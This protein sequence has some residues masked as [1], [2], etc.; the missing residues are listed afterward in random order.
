MSKMTKSHY[1]PFLYPAKLSCW[2]KL[3]SGTFFPLIF[4]QS[5]ANLGAKCTR[6]G[7]R[8]C[9]IFKTKSREAV[10]Y[11]SRQAS[12]TRPDSLFYTLNQVLIHRQS[13]KGNR[14]GCCSNAVPTE[15][16][17]MAETLEGFMIPTTSQK[18][19]DLLLDY[20]SDAI[21]HRQSAPR[22]AAFN[23]HARLSS[24]PRGTHY[25][26]LK[27]HKSLLR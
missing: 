23:L 7:E 19:D 18:R 20:S 27:V 21:H 22:S 11:A 8:S 13:H 5:W 9:R 26:T 24:R 16:S 14:S 10:Y 3:P 1:N 25:E 2:Q 4:R 17:W 12:L 6:I 15:I